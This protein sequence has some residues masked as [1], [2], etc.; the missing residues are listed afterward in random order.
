MPAGIKS[1]RVPVVDDVMEN[2]PV[3]AYQHRNRELALR[4]GILLFHM[5]L[6]FDHPRN[7]DGTA[8]VLFNRVDRLVFAVAFVENHSDAA[9]KQAR[10]ND[11][12]QAY[13]NQFA[14]VHRFSSVPSM[15]SYSTSSRRL[16]NSSYSL[17]VMFFSLRRRY[18]KYS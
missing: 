8:T 7:D 16:T 4:T 11:L 14:S 13:Q 3:I 5:A 12:V 18:V 15:A 2:A 6:A 17:S 1:V 9:G 10:Q